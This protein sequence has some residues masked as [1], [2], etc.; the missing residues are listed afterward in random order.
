MRLMLFVPI[1]LMGCASII[2]QHAA[3]RDIRDQC[4][5]AVRIGGAQTV[6]RAGEEWCE[7]ANV[8]RKYY[9]TK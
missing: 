1:M 4:W 3:F 5:V 2:P 6:E 9:I 7:Y 8:P